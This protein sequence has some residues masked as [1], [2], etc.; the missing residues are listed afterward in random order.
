MTFA[1]LAGRTINTTKIR[2]IVDRSESTSR[3]VLDDGT[4]FECADYELDA[5][6]PLLPALPGFQIVATGID[7]TPTSPSALRRE[8]VRNMMSEA[9]IF[10]RE[11]P[12]GIRPVTPDHT[13]WSR[14]LGPDCAIVGPGGEASGWSGSWH[15]TAQNWLDGRVTALAAELCLGDTGRAG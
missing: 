8:L 11:H 15:P 6:Y 14:S 1:R 3:I 7:A 9:I 4:T 10:W 2:E 5:I 13:E 12:D